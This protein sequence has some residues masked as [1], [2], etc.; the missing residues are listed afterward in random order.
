MVDRNIVGNFS[1]SGNKSLILDR[2]IQSVLKSV[3]VGSFN[4]RSD[5]FIV[6][7]KGRFWFIKVNLKMFFGDIRSNDILAVINI[8]RSFN[9]FFSV[10]LLDN[11]LSFNSLIVI[12]S[13]LSIYKSDFEI[14]FLN[15]RLD[16][17]L[18]DIFIGR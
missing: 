3:L 5:D 18:V 1:G 6:L 10:F 4:S 13:I 7:S 2:N 15:N 12:N 17:G 8:T 9:G 14:F 11:R 16:D